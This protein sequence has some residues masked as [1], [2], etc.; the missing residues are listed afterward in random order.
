[1]QRRWGQE[2]VDE[3]M[4][5]CRTKSAK[6][7]RDRRKWLMEGS[8][9]QSANLHGFKCSRWRRLWRQRILD[10]II[11]AHF[12]RLRACASLAGKRWGNHAPESRILI[13]FA[14]LDPRPI[15]Q[16]RQLTLGNSTVILDFVSL[17]KIQQQL[18][19]LSPA[20]WR[21]FLQSRRSFALTSAARVCH[22]T[23]FASSARWLDLS[24]LSA[25]LHIN[26]VGWS[27]GATAAAWVARELGETDCGCEGGAG[28]PIE[29]N[30]LGLYDAVEMIPASLLTPGHRLPEWYPGDQGPPNSVPSNVRNFF[31]AKKTGGAFIR[32][33]GIPLPTT[34]FGH[35]DELGFRLMTP[36]WD[37][38]GELHYKSDRSQ[39]G[40]S[41]DATAAHVAMLRAAASAGVPLNLDNPLTHLSRP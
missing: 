30:F 15:P 31:R 18:D 22:A 2:L 37:G 34:N 10:H 21:I 39:I 23:C 19:L 38:D 9:A 14:Y 35:E 16:T 4:A 17:S 5:Q 20:L 29:V 6:L 28:Q 24:Q 25:S 1:M 7:S 13:T 8:F 40:T 41:P 26:L 32:S 3:G 33:G 11:C 12:R 27:R 36:W